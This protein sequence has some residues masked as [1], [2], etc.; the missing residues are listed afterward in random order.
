[1]RVDRGKMDID[2]GDTFETGGLVIRILGLDTPEIKHPEHG[3]Y[4]DQPFGR[5]ATIKAVALFDS[6]AVI[7]YLPHQSDRYGR[8]LAHVFVDGELFPVKMIEAGLAYETVSFYGDN[9]FPDLAALISE[10][11]L[12]AGDPPFQNPNEW[13]KGNRNG[14]RKSLVRIIKDML[15][16]FD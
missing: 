10:A 4:Q 9:G 11:A 16:W 12:R 3:F 14:P 2:D 15:K 6:A 1:M 13:R 5:E 7:E 8:M